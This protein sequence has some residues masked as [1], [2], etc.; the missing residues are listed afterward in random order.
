LYPCTESSPVE[1]G[2]YYLSSRYYDPAIGRFINADGYASTGQGVLGYN[3][4]VY[5]SNNPVNR[6]DPNGYWPSFIGALEGIGTIIV[7]KIVDTLLAVSP[8]ASDVGGAKPFDDITGGKN[9]PNCYGYATGDYNLTH[10]GAFSGTLVYIND[11]ESAAKGVRN[12]MR[13]KTRSIRKI[14]G[15]DAK[16][17]RFEYKIALRVGTTPYGYLDHV[18]ELYDFHFMVQTNTGQWAE[19]HGTGGDAI[20]WDL[21]MTPDTIPWTDG[22]KEYYDS[23]IIYFAIS[24]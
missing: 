17:F 21:G 24:H 23:E 15:P 1:T 18:V 3:M 2:F 4:Y 19:K 9:T 5:C 20:L 7:D 6:M 22:E 10:P 13:A 11:V 14:K 16:V 8:F 12:D